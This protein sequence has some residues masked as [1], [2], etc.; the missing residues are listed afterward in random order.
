[1]ANA[2]HVAIL[3]EGVARW[4]RWRDQYPEVRPDLLELELPVGS[5]AGI[6]LSGADLRGGDLG[7]SDAR[8]SL[9]GP[10]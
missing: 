5:F 9:F 6:D 10:V 8:I 4:N 7:E 1:M 2:E 3:N